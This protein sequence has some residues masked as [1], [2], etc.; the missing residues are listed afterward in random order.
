MHERDLIATFGPR[1]RK[2]KKR[3]EFVSVYADYTIPD[4]EVA[5]RTYTVFF[6]MDNRTGR[7]SQVLVRLNEMK[8]KV[9]REDVFTE[10]E[11]LLTRT[12]GDPTSKID[13]RPNYFGTSHRWIDL[14]RTWRFR[15]T[16]IELVYD[17]SNYVDSSVLGIKYIQAANK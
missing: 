10:L 17:W 3:A 8:S 11:T 14:N 1:L 5:A 15:T 2:L 9:P 6:E 12:L 4:F 7:L 16:T 13:K